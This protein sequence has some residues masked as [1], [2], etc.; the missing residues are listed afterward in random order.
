[1][2]RDNRTRLIGIAALIA[3]AVWLSALF[4]GSSEL[5]VTFLDVGDGLCTIVRTPSGRTLVMDCGTS[6]WGESSDKVGTTLVAPYL[7]RLGLDG[8]DVA[9]LSHPHSDHDCGFP[10]LLEVEPA[11]LVLD[12]G[13]ECRSPE[14]FAFLRAV[15]TAHARYR[16]A[17]RGQVLDMGDGVRARILSPSPDENYTNLNDHSIVLRITYK[18]VAFLLPADACDAAEQDM[19]HADTNVRAQ[20]LQVGHHG[21]RDATSAEWLSAVRPRIAVISCA[22]H[23]QYHFPSRLVLDRLASRGA[24]TYTTAQYGAVT[25]ETDGETISVQTVRQP[26]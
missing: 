4:A 2:L 5:R 15:R 11:R 14:Y 8:I 13:A 9:V 24:R 22:R 10:G 25:V 18:R 16:I 20:V 21:S 6:S 17:R 3:L 7:Q 1:M 23:S 26:R 12:C 19:L